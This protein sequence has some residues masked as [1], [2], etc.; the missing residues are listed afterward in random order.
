MPICG[1]IFHA[2]FPDK[3][4]IRHIIYFL[5]LFYFSFMI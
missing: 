5:E 2:D 3:I 1:L 4:H